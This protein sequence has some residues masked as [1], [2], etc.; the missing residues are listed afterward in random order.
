MRRPRGAALG[1]AVGTGASR[2]TGLLRT[3]ALAWALGVTPL[4]DAYNSA[5]TT[6]NILFQLALGGVL[7]SALVPTLVRQGEGEDRRSAAGAILGVAIVLGLVA[8][9]VMAVGAPLIIRLLTFGARGRADYGEFVAV[10]ETWMRLFAAQ[11][12]GYAVSAVAVG[13][14]GSRRRLALGAVAPVLTNVITIAAA[15]AFGLRSGAPG[16]PAD[17]PLTPG[18]AAGADV[19]LLG[20]G[21]TVGVLAMAAVQVW[22]A[23][24]SEP[25]LRVR[26]SLRHP[27]I[28]ALRRLAGWVLLYVAANQVGLA[29]V[30][31]LASSVPGGQSAYFWAFGIMQLP[32][33]VVAVSLLS[34]VFPL[35]AKAASEGRDPT[36]DAAPAVRTGA[37]LLLPAAVGLGFVARPLGVLLVGADGAGLVAGALRGFAVSLVFFSAY[38]LL[39]RVAYA[40]EDTRTPAFVSIAVN[41]VDPAVGALSIVLF[42]DPV[43]RLTGLGL[44]H[45]ASYLTGCVVLVTL[46]VRAGRLRLGRLRHPALRWA[47]VATLAMA[48]VLGAGKVSGWL[49]A[50]DASRL[51]AL[52]AT[53]IIV[54]LG[55]STYGATLFG[56]RRTR[57]LV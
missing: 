6:P 56:L 32:H 9:V 38:Q 54:A 55:G 25:G 15:I 27:A 44:G 18:Q 20:V 11:I 30:L 22:G 10:G 43:A 50:G 17:N 21:T 13:I 39:T 5:N 40:F 26:F 4:A 8:S 29:I 14:L 37:L 28:R 2:V 46:L 36:D 47:L 41:V 53:A 52:W 49:P 16:R 33:A 31:S 23:F 45:A 51:D 35:M 19:W 7:G 42:D 57:R 34:A 1:M 12:L 48:A 24:R 3:V